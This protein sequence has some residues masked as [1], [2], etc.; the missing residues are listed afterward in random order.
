MDIV[1]L[2]RSITHLSKYRG[3][4]EADLII[5]AFVKNNLHKLSNKQIIELHQLLLLDDEYF[6]YSIKGSVLS[7]KFKE[8]YNE[9]QTN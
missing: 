4:K 2:K 5:S 3:S 1:K 6:F 7:N 9:L 8:F